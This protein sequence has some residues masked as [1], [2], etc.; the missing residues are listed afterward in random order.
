MS[1]QPDRALGTPDFGHDD[2]SPDPGVT[3]ALTAYA[4]GDGGSA[5]VLN[6]LAAGRLLVPVVAVAETGETPAEGGRRE[7]TSHMASVSTI[8][9]DGR[10]GLLAFTSVETM[11]RWNP[12]AR[13][14][15]VTSRRA[16]ES[17][18][19]D[20]AEALVID[21]AGPVTFAVDAGELRALAA[22]WRPL[23]DEHGGTTWAEAVGLAGR[24]Q[25]P[26]GEGGVAAR[27]SGTRRGGPV[28]ALARV[29][30]QAGRALRRSGR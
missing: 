22:G 3:A 20:G 24:Q 27:T 11:R 30:T 2:G 6:A 8:G 1:L 23:G 17:A 9:R 13:P 7:R 16:A 18:L 5:D 26:V 28:G 25:G 15:P 12:A 19:A 29:V 21:L 14:V 10:R 4:H